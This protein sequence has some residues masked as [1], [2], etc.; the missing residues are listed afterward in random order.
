MK[1]NKNPPCQKGSSDREPVP[2]CHEIKE[3]LR[4]KNVEFEGI[5]LAANKEARDIVIAKTGHIGTPIV[6]IGDEYIFGFDQKKMESQL[7]QT[8]E[9]KEGFYSSS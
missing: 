2:G 5:D 8:V 4:S 7:K 6:Q 3:F 9:S 1:R